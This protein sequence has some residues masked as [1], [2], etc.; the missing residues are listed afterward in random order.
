MT[1]VQDKNLPECITYVSDA[2]T[3]KRQGSNINGQRHQHHLVHWTSPLLSATEQGKLKL[4]P[5]LL[6]YES[7]GS[8]VN[9]I[10]LVENREMVPPSLLTFVR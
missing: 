1:C 5:T 9:L 10:M 2:V 7:S 4:L 6:V 3:L 8:T